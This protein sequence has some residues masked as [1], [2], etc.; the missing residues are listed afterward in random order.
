MQ[1]HLGKVYAVPLTLM[2]YILNRPRE[3]LPE[4]VFEVA[5][6]CKQ[7]PIRRPASHTTAAVNMQNLQE[8]NLLKYRDGASREEVRQT[9]PD[10]PSDD[11][12]LDIQQQALLRQQQR[13]INSLRRGRAADYFDMVSAGQR[14]HEQRLNS[15]EDPGRHLL[16]DSESAFIN[17]SDDSFLLQSRRDQR[18]RPAVRKADMSEDV[19]NR[20]TRPDRS[21]DS[22][23]VHSIT[24]TEIEWLRERTKNKMTLL[25]NM[26]EHDWRSGE[27]S[28]EEGVELWPQAPPSTD[29]RVSIDTLA[30]DPWL[31]PS[32]SETLKRFV[33]G[34]RPSSQTHI[35]QDW[36]GPS[37][38]HG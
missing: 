16:L 29:R 15:A 38:Y 27:G 18:A 7:V 36:E 25:N 28:A 11:Y 19:V 8:F 31:R 17:P 1:D 23:S 5:R 2:L 9:Y 32:S 35:G 13:T 33:G 10:S 20:Y 14:H 24:S 12:S 34:R 37:T 6:L 21:P 4:D 30:T 26:R 3:H 22:Q